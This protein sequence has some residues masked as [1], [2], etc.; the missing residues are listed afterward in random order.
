MSSSVSENFSCDS[1]R[2]T[3]TRSACSKALATAAR[4]SPLSPQLQASAPLLYK[5]INTIA[6]TTHFIARLLDDTRHTAC[7]RPGRGSKRHSNCCDTPVAAPAL[8][9]KSL[10]VPALW[11]TRD[12]LRLVSWQGTQPSDH[13]PVHAVPDRKAGR[14]ETAGA[15]LAMIATR[16]K[17]A[18]ARRSAAECRAP[19]STACRTPAHDRSR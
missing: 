6:A 13:C 10:R 8:P 17:A 15:D 18:R 5:L 3:K 19:P 9:P 7:C 12:R 4:S 1:T 16:P 11:H 14:S 2:P